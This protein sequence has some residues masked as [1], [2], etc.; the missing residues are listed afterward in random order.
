MVCLG[1]KNDKVVPT[2]PTSKLALV[3]AGLCEKKDV[4]EHVQCAEA[5]LLHFVIATFP[6]LKDCG[7][8]DVLR[9]VP[10]SKNLESI[11]VDVRYLPHL[12]KT[13]VSSG[14]PF[15]GPIQQDLDMTP[16]CGS[17]SPSTK[18]REYCNHNNYILMS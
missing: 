17:D 11:P 18:V 6:K 12:L 13:V 1:G 16:L 7:G 10:N 4:V 8:F 3:R 5:E 2:S 14:R 15:I 9:C